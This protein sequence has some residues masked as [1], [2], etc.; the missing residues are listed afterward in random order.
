MTKN[1]YTSKIYRK[2]RL[3][4]LSNA[5]CFPKILTIIPWKLLATWNICYNYKTG[6]AMC[7]SLH[8]QTREAQTDLFPL[9]KCCFLPTFGRCCSSLMTGIVY[10]P[11]HA[12]LPL[13]GPTPCYWSPS[14]TFSA[15]LFPLF[16]CLQLFPLSLLP[17]TPQRSYFV[18]F[19][20]L[21]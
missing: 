17:F 20:S 14:H 21:P 3:A 5:V 4:I 11:Y 12:C 13:L 16:F 2:I 18:N 7:L 15:F 10:H 8:K 9:D 6:A 19:C 1:S